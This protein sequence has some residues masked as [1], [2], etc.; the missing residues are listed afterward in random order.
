MKLAQG[1][2]LARLSADR[3]GLQVCLQRR[4]RTRIRGR[5]VTATDLLSRLQSALE[6]LRGSVAGQRRQQVAGINSEAP[7]QA[8]E[9]VDSR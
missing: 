9:R 7:R 1:L 8:V 4:P 6:Q 5:R 2:T 3:F